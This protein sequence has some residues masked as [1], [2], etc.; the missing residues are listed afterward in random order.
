NYDG[1]LPGEVQLSVRQYRYPIQGRQE[2][3]VASSYLLQ[4]EPG[5]RIPLYPHLNPRFH[6]PAEEGVP[7][8]LVAAGT[9]IAPY[10]A[11][12]QQLQA[13]GRRRPVWIAFQEQCYA[14]DFLYQREWQEALEE[15]R[16]ER[17]DCTFLQEA[18]EL[19]ATD[20]LLEQSERLEDWL[21]R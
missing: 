16:V 15:G 4:A 13:Q 1:D 2:A 6:L 18:P 20:L 7:L 8:I 14:E 3:G 19:G 9:G 17:F 12:L 11:F 5:E 21:Q 10:R